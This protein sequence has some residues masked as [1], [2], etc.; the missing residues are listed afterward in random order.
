MAAK[1]AL[2]VKLYYR[3]GE[4]ADVVG[5]EPHVL[6]YWESEFGTIRPQKSPKGQR[7]YSRKDLEKLLRV[8]ELLYGQGYTIA[9]AKKRL[10]ELTARSPKEA[11]GSLDELSRASSEGPSSVR[12]SSERAP[13]SPGESVSRMVLE[14]PSASDAG[15]S[16]AGRSGAGRSGAGRS[17]AGPFERGVAAQRPEARGLVEP[18]RGGVS[19]EAPKAALETAA[20][21]RKFSFAF[22]DEDDVP[23]L[24]SVP[25]LEA[26]GTPLDGV[27][28][29]IPELLVPEERPTALEVAALA[30]GGADVARLGEA[31]RRR[32]SVLRDRLEGELRTLARRRE[33]TG[34]EVARAFEGAGVETPEERRIRG[35]T[36]LDGRA[37]SELT[38]GR[39]R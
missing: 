30:P 23:A 19:F 11:D 6:R 39:T 10:R 20:P 37:M 9:G 15:W 13:S 26:R 12:G 16:G 2:P 1:P 18:P 21:V 5:V 31:A 29:S 33:E 7:V 28:A 25:P 8:K 27:P 35:R 17:G 32:L 22:V 38:S 4:V 36:S 34:A 24:E 3:I 14:S